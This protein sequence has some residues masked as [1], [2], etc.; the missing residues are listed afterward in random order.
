MRNQCAGDVMC[1]YFDAMRSY[2]D[3]TRSYRDATP[4]AATATRRHAQLPRGHARF[5]LAMRVRRGS[6]QVAVRLE[7][8]GCPV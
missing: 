3:A 6:S 1:S 8:A 4:R 7:Y 5:Q 2:F